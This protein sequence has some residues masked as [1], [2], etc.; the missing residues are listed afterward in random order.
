MVKTGLNRL[1][2]AI[3]L[4]FAVS[5][6][7]HADNWRLIGGTNIYINKIF[8]PSND[9]NKVIVC[10]DAEETDF[11]AMTVNYGSMGHGFKF[12][13]NSGETFADYDT[14]LLYYNVYDI[15]QLPNKPETW[16]AAVKYYNTRG[17]LMSSDNGA[18]WSKEQMLHQEPS[19]VVKLA[20]R[21]N[22][23]K[24]KIYGAILNTVSGE[25]FVYSEDNFDTYTNS[26]S[27]KA[28]LRDI[29]IS[30]ANN[31]LIFAAVDNSISGKQGVYRSYNDGKTWLKDETGIEYLRILCVHPMSNNP[32]VVFCG[33]D[34]ITPNTKSIGK[35]IYMSEDTGKTWI[36]IGAPGFTVYDIVEHPSNPQFLIAACD[37]G[38]VL[39]SSDG[40]KKWGAMNAGLPEGESV[41][42]VGIPNIAANNDGITAFAGVHGKGLYKTNRIISSVEDSRN[43]T[44]G[45]RI[46]S[47]YPQPVSE[48]AT[49]RFY[50]PSDQNIRAYITDYLGKQVST[51]VDGFFAEGKQVI[52]L[53]INESSASSMYYLVITDGYNTVT[54]KL[55]NVK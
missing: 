2:L 18:T 33:A 50:N 31:S 6:A 40:G 25:G 29:E 7:L 45:L 41:R 13:T 16:F 19:Q 39:V 42:C 37:K 30:K 54:Q 3:L 21:Q 51:V 11:S 49:V 32:A 48:E 1:L 53:Y 17:I 38:G 23:D 28:E 24:S 14:A 12:S 5:P 15:I 8:F 9:A 52:N 35:G 46:E 55:L 27:L 43:N 22:G 44:G 26:D 10:S 20:A 34:S 36:K 4:T 47:V